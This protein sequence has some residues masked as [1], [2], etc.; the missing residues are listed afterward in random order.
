MRSLSDTRVKYP[1]TYE[2]SLDTFDNRV[3]EN[4]IY[5]PVKSGKRVICETI[6]Q[7]TNKGKNT[8]NYYFSGL[9]RK[10]GKPQIEELNQYGIQCFVSTQISNDKQTIIDKINHAIQLGNEVVLHID[11][12]DYGSEGSQIVGS[13]LK[14][15][16]QIE[17]VSFFMYTATPWELTSAP[18]FMK[19]AKVF[20]FVPPESYRGADWFLDNDLVHET[21]EDFVCFN[22]AGK[23]MISETGIEWMKKWANSTDKKR[24]WSVVRISTKTNQSSEGISSKYKLFKNS[25][26]KTVK[27]LSIPRSQVNEIFPE[28]QFRAVFVDEET[29]F[30]FGDY[31]SWD[32]HKN[33]TLHSDSETFHLIVL[34]QT[35]TRSTEWGF[36]DKLFFY[37]SYESTKANATTQIQRQQRVAHYH[38]IGNPINVVTS[39]I[40]TWLLSADRMSVEEYISKNP[41]RSIHQRTSKTDNTEKKDRYYIFEGD[42]HVIVH[43]AGKGQMH[44]RLELLSSHPLLLERI[45]H[46]GMIITDNDTGEIIDDLRGKGILFDWTNVV[47]TH[48][49]KSKTANANVA[50]YVLEGKFGLSQGWHKACAQLD[51]PS[52]AKFGNENC[53]QSWEDLIGKEKRVEEFYNEKKRRE[54]LKIKEPAPLC[55]AIY[56]PAMEQVDEPYTVAT[57]KKSV[58]SQIPNEIMVEA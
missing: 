45:N 32:G 26:N 31:A 19:N 24:N 16:H 56:L 57:K 44:P 8:L 53:P 11:E 58:Y 46:P 54:K 10:D 42:P 23:I 55:F 3:K 34:N 41:K 27:T 29:A 22:E 52:G 43:P 25:F 5:A 14:D 40:D 18:S 38:D 12:A 7:Y 49:A 28:Q 17:N 4:V 48:G 36:H 13:F 9:N 47:S 2:F 20:R 1:E 33:S 6:S 39:D 30:H 50:R 35:S 37:Y 15:V 51:G 21:Q